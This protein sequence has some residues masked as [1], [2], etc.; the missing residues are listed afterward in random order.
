ME[1]KSLIIK[2]FKFGNMKT[3]TLLSIPVLLVF[4]SLGTHAQFLSVSGTIQDN[5]SGKTIKQISIVEGKSGIGTISSANGT[6]WLLLKKGEVKLSF[7]DDNYETLNSTFV[8]RKD[9][10]ILV[11]LNAIHKETNRKVKQ[12]SSGQSEYALNQVSGKK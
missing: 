9:T 7:S 8:L 5:L 6:Y 10:T 1:L 3:I 2:P 12:L 11:K 4:F